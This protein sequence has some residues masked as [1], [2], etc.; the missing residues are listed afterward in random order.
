L[1]KKRACLGGRSSFLFG[2]TEVCFIREELI[3]CADE[4]KVPSGWGN[5]PIAVGIFPHYG[6]DFSPL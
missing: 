1:Q 6:G 4:I 2:K 5:K 3:A